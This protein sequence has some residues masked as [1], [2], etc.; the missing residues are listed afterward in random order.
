MGAW[1]QLPARQTMAGGDLCLA[2]TMLGQSRA[3]RQHPFLAASPGPSSTAGLLY[4]DG[5]LGRA[6]SCRLTCTE[7]R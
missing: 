1:K 5:S 7:G 4:L 2:P 6:S 3:A